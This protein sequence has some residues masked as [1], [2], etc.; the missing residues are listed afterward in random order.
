MTKYPMVAMTYKT[1]ELANTANGVPQP[2]ENPGKS[3]K[4][5]TDSIVALHSYSILGAHRDTATGK[6]YIVLRNP[7]GMPFLNSLRGDPV[8]VD[9]NP[10]TP[11]S[12]YYKE[13]NDAL[14]KNIWKV[15]LNT[16]VGETQIDMSKNDGIFALA[17]DKFKWHFN[18]FGWVWDSATH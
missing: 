12:T 11:F 17:A 4:Y 3:V 10:N 13:M 8:F 18:C 15:R 1:E 2:D 6:K 7:W 14:Y 9:P 16:G 5:T